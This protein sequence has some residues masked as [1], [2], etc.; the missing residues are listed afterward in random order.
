MISEL[1]FDHEEDRLW[2]AAR[3]TRQLYPPD[4]EYL[5]RA[6]LETDTG[7]LDKLERI[8]LDGADPSETTIEIDS[9]PNRDNYFLTLYV[10]PGPKRTLREAIKLFKER[11]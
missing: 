3:K 6:G 9:H 4:K 7:L 11:K 2:R 8:A 5:D 10:T 1:R